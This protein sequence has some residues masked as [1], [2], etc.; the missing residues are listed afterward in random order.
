MVVPLIDNRARR[1]VRCVSMTGLF[2]GRAVVR[3]L[4]F[5]IA[6]VAVLGHVCA[7]PHEADAASPEAAA[8][9]DGH[10]GHSE[11]DAL[12]AASC[13]AVTPSVTSAAPVVQAAAPVAIAASAVPGVVLSRTPRSSA[14][15]ISPPLFLLHSAL[16]I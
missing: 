14:S 3:W 7:L 10:D 1:R 11:H 4:G 9:H 15:A 12:H 8:D 5:S 16:R 2:G 6:L 13:E